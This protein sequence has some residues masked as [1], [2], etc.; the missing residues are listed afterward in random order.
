MVTLW[1]GRALDKRLAPAAFRQVVGGRV[2]TRR[3]EW[4]TLVYMKSEGVVQRRRDAAATRAAIL[5][6]A[7]AEFT[8]HG[9]AGAGVRQ[10]AERAGVTAMLINRYFDSKERLFAEAV[11]TSFA[12]P[13]VVTDSGEDRLAATIGTVLARRT[14]LSAGQLDPFLLTLRSAGDARAAEIVRHG[15]E[16]HVGARL[17][18]RL[19]GSEAEARAQ[20][21]LALIAGV[22]LMRRVIGLPAL[23]AMADET[24]AGLLGAMF[25][26]VL[27]PD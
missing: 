12:P 4:S 15:I 6:A 14:G 24:L 11:D 27:D 19:A 7:I 18:S 9:Y 22:W 1:S 21:A 2:Y 26:A 13:T 23:A 20:I 25:D 8:E 16:T 3:Q 5:E 10:I 17:A